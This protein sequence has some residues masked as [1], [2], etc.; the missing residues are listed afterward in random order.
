MGRVTNALRHM[1]NTFT[2]DPA[3]RTQAEA[4]S[5]YGSSYGGTSRP[6]SVRVRVS[7]ERSI[8]SS[9]YSRLAVD[10]ASAE[11]KHVRCDET[12]KYISDMSSGLNDCLTVEA[13]IDQTPQQFLQDLAITLFDKG[14]AAIVP[15]DM[16][17]NPATS[18]S[19]DVETWRVGEIVA[20]APR[21]VRVRVYN[22]Q[23]DKG[24][25]EEITLDKQ[26]VGIVEN[27]FYNIMN[28]PNSTLQRLIHKL[29]LLDSVDEASASGKLNMIIQLPYVVKT[30]ARRQQAEKRRKDIEFQLKSNQYGIAYT[31]GTEKITQLNTPANN[32]LMEQVTYLQ[33]VLYDQ[34]GIT[35]EIMNGSADEKTMLNYYARTVKPILDAIKLELMRKFLTKTAR[36]QGQR[37]LFFKNPF[38]LMP[39]SQFAEVADVLSRNEIFA[40]NELR[41]FIGVKPSSDP[42]ADKLQNSNMPSGT[43]PGNSQPSNGSTPPSDTS[44]SPDAAN[45]A[46]DQVSQAIDEAF[47]GLGL[48]DAAS[49][50]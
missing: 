11:F 34:L 16:T 1:F 28:E 32:N 24:F 49:N 27:P 46:L 18:G 47:S 21:H 22:D 33:G 3:S 5:T 2:D 36:S 14:V 17:L 8:I 41:Q 25:R 48:N 4:Y 50:G 6:Y 10:V 43:T 20:W 12:G 44:G 38:E 39:I 42:S 13:N 35:K 31:D 45:A 30:E 40:P 23:P 7:N 26:S 15:V 29:N 37:I 19:W 9:I